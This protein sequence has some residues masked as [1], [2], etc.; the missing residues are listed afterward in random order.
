[1]KRI[2]GL[3]QGILAI[4]VLLLSLLN[5]LP[6]VVAEEEDSNEEEITLKVVATLGK[7]IKDTEFYEA[8]YHSRISKKRVKNKILVKIPKD[9]PMWKDSLGKLTQLTGKGNL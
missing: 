9:L 4:L 6:G 8:T 7:K 2:R 1:M 3:E 5:Q